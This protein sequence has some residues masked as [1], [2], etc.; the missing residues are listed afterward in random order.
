M[1]ENLLDGA[2]DQVTI[3]QNKNYVEELVGEGRKFKSVEDLARGKFESDMFIEQL[4][5]ENA[6]YRADFIKERQDNISRAKLEEMLTK[7]QIKEQGTSNELT[8]NVNE[9]IKPMNDPK[10]LES[11]ISSKIQEYEATKRQVDNFNSV[12]AKLNEHLGSNYQGVV[13]QQLES[14]GMSEDTLNRLARNEPNAVYRLFGIDN[15][16][17]QDTFQAP[18]KASFTNTFTPKTIKK[19]WNYYEDMRVKN[20]SLYDNPQTQKQMHQDAIALGDA[21]F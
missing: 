6:Q 11:L 1:T 13:K 21:F 20:K 2:N 8:P 7:M 14:L 9:T 12:K 17:K 4:K 5:Q 18:P 16:T 15:Q 10:E 19:D 3:D